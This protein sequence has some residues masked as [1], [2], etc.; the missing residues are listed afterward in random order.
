MKKFLGII[1]IIFILSNH[2]YAAKWEWVGSNENASYYLDEESVQ[3]EHASQKNLIAIMDCWIKIEYIEP[4]DDGTKEKLMEYGFKTINKID[5]AFFTPRM[6][7][8]YDSE[9]KVI[10]MDS[11]ESDVWKRIPPGTFG[12]L[13]Y[14]KVIDYIH[15]K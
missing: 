8:C 14:W 13:I 11:S 7:L 9:G 5:N 12:E 6:I 15:N 3:V 1:F 10:T 4:I 2:V